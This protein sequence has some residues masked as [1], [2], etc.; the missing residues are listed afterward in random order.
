MHHRRHSQPG[1]ARATRTEYLAGSLRSEKVHTGCLGVVPGGKTVLR[2]ELLHAA[3]AEGSRVSTLEELD[4]GR[5]DLARW[6]HCAV[7]GK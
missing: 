2:L 5:T 4:P 1:A 7:T 6:Y 3:D